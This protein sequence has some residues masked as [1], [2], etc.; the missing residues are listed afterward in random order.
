[1]NLKSMISVEMLIAAIV[2]GVCGYI[3]LGIA[4]VD[5][6]LSWSVAPVI[7]VFCYLVLIPLS[8]LLK[9]PKTEGGKQ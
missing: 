6:P 3:L 8:V 5:N 1:M 9:K 4:P 2:V 7:L